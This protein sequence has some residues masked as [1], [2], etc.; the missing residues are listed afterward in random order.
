MRVHVNSLNCDQAR[1]VV[2]VTG[3][4]RE[5]IRAATRVVVIGNSKRDGVP[6]T[7]PEFHG[8]RLSCFPLKLPSRRPARSVVLLLRLM[9]LAVFERD[10]GDL[11]RLFTNCRRS[12]A[13]P[14]GARARSV[15]TDTVC[16]CLCMC[17]SVFD[18]TRTR[19]FVL[20][21]GTLLRHT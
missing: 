12:H 1:Q 5:E 2:T 16:V 9:S 7:S 20:T 15:I 6:G 3:E 13:K 14:E 17:V 4:I 19:Q 8:A 11:G 10:V 21:R 18:A